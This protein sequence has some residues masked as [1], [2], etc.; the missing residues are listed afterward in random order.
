MVYLQPAFDN[1]SA[2]ITAVPANLKG[3]ARLGLEIETSLQIQQRKTISVFEGCNVHVLLSAG[4]SAEGDS[5]TD[6]IRG[7]VYPWP[8][9]HQA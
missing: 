9:P 3:N 5:A 1:K 7:L 2:A 8:L 6:L 4:Q